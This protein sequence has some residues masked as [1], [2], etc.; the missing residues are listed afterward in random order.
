MT[1]SGQ[2]ELPY[3]DQVQ[4]SG[5]VARLTQREADRLV[6]SLAELRR[7]EINSYWNLCRRNP[8]EA[9]R[10]CLR[11][12]AIV[13]DLFLLARNTTRAIKPNDSQALREL[14]AKLLDNEAVAEA[15]AEEVSR[16]PE[17]RPAEVFWSEGAVVGIKIVN[18]EKVFV[19]R[20]ASIDLPRDT[21]G[22]DQHHSGDTWYLER[23]EAFEDRDR[24]CDV[25]F[26]YLTG[27][28]SGDEAWVDL[29]LPP[30]DRHEV[31]CTVMATESL[32][33]HGE[34]R[35]REYHSGLIPDFPTSVN[36]TLTQLR[37]HQ[38]ALRIAGEQSAEQRAVV[39]LRTEKLRRREERLEK[40][41]AMLERA[42]KATREDIAE[43]EARALEEETGFSRGDRVRHKATGEEGLIEI[44]KRNRAHFRLAET[45]DTI[46]QEIRRG[47]WDRIDTTAH[48]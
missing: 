20:F 28:M 45:Y 31:E 25:L 38:A 18:G 32:A 41:L 6:S 48:Q 4:I 14:T 1:R 22:L 39:A 19:L 13:Q 30:R 5:D 27:T 37:A 12:P 3:T 46:T 2:L 21:R 9:E 11:A 43:I 42:R 16:V 36:T 26:V 17:D 40:R 23:H 29:R 47:E 10:M 34:I 44:D 7:N 35:A 8:A 33:L 15:L 24:E